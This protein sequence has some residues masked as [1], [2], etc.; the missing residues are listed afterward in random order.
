MKTKFLLPARYKVLGWILFL[1]GFSFGSILLFEDFDEPQWLVVQVPDFLNQDFFIGEKPQVK[2][3]LKW[4]ENNL[5]D[6][7]SLT[8]I[9]AGALLLML[10]KQKDEDELI[11]R[12]RLESLLWAALVNGVLILLATWLI[13][14]M[15]FFSVMMVYMPLFYLLFILRFQFSLWRFKAIGNEE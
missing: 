10:A 12:I 1:S 9:I 15:A 5:S 2:N 3:G 6:E 7:L 4:I 11:M 14:G 8:F 13:Y